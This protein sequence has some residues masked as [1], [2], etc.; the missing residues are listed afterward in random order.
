MID[1]VQ[2]RAIEVRNEVVKPQREQRCWDGVC[3]Y[4][5]SLNEAEAL[6][7]LLRDDVPAL[8]AEVR[9]LRERADRLEGALREFQ[10]E[11]ADM[12]WREQDQDTES[13]YRCPYCG[14]DGNNCCQ[15]GAVT[16]DDEGDKYKDCPYRW[17]PGN[18]CCKYGAAQ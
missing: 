17:G 3:A 9:R 14:G 15:Y 1:E 8:I 7:P 5:I 18:N 6:W 16:M 2:L 12:A 11:L 4:T 10:I 13:E